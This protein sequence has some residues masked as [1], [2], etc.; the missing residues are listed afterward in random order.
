MICDAPDGGIHNIRMEAH[1]GYSKNSIEIDSEN[2]F[3]GL[4]IKESTS[5]RLKI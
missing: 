2:S 1:G 4:S 3:S 5:Y